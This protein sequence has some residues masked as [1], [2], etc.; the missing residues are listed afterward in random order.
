MEWI[1]KIKDW[2]PKGIQWISRFIAGFVKMY[3][4]MASWMLEGAWYEVLFK[5]FGAIGV[6]AT[7]R[8]VYFA[9]SEMEGS[10]SLLTR[11]LNLLFII[12]TFGFLAL[13]AAMAWLLFFG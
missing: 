2:L 4:E 1:D 13:L 12:A 11:V 8:A 5:F 10:D 6:V 3:L 7:L 9:A